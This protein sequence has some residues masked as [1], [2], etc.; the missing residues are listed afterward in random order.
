M[1][2]LVENVCLNGR[3][4]TCSSCV[5]YQQ[6]GC[7]RVGITRPNSLVLV[8]VREEEWG[9]QNLTFSRLHLYHC[10]TTAGRLTSALP[11]LLWQPAQEL[12]TRCKCRAVGLGLVCSAR[13]FKLMCI[14]F[15][16]RMETYLL[17]TTFVMYSYLLC[18]R[19]L[20]A[21]S[22][23]LLLRHMHICRGI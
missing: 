11:D 22:R 14:I 13:K 8:W 10:V 16:C 4:I 23:P 15:C 7:R 5:E 1:W 18:H 19:N 9:K 12:A 20:A 6:Q 2:T 17:T 3:S 21:C